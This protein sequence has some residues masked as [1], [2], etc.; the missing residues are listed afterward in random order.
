[1]KKEERILLFRLEN[2]SRAG[3]VAQL[4]R[5]PSGH[6]KVARSELYPW[7]AKSWVCMRLQS[8][9]R[10]DGILYFCENRQGQEDLLVWRL[11][12]G[13]LSHW[14][15]LEYLWTILF[16]SSGWKQYPL[17]SPEPYPD[18]NS[19]PEPSVWNKCSICFSPMH[20]PKSDWKC[21][22]ASYT[23]CEFGI[24]QQSVPQNVF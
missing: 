20:F 3:R 11:G 24:R 9:L 21:S 19:N 6:T 15:M 14:V 16:C 7:G 17:M 10:A 8:F 23:V 4:L 5:A 2:S 18:G 13:F 22:E 12:S 1:M